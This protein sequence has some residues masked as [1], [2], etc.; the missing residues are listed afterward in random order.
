VLDEVGAVAGEREQA[1]DGQR[2]FDVALELTWREDD[3]AG[4]A[5]R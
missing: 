1:P 4:G 2:E 5:S 3:D